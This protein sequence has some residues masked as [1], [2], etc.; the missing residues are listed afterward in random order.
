MAA[1]Q[2][3]LDQIQSIARI[4]TLEA[5]PGGYAKRLAD[6]LGDV[7]RPEEVERSRC[8]KRWLAI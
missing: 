4:G 8:A 2:H 1:V 5:A 3:L 7:A 6:E